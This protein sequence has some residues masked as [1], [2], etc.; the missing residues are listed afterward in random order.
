LVRGERASQR[1]PSGFQYPEHV[2]EFG[3]HLLDQ[4]AELRLIFLRVVAF[5]ALTG[6]ADREA[7]VVQ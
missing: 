1:W 3:D 2:F 7:L 5:E 6:T 4:Q